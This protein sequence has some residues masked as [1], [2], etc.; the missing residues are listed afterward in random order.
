MKD[1][2]LQMFTCVIAVV[3]L[4]SLEYFWMATYSDTNDKAK[5][6]T[7]D[8]CIHFNNLKIFHSYIAQSCSMSAKEKHFSVNL[9]LCDATVNYCG[10]S[11]DD[12]FAI[13]GW[14][15]FDH[16]LRPRICK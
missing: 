16:R 8:R 13:R 10:W 5:I 7:F 15:D 2:C 1:F 11:P 6:L 12:P 4:L 14:H 9:A 3:K